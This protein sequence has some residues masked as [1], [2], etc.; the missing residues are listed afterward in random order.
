MRFEPGC[1]GF[2]VQYFLHF[3]SN[4]AFHAHFN[5]LATTCIKRKANKDWLQFCKRHW[6]RTLYSPVTFGYF[7]TR[8]SILLYNCKKMSDSFNKKMYE[9]VTVLVKCRKTRSK[10]CLFCFRLCLYKLMINMVE[11]MIKINYF[12]LSLK[13]TV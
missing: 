9:L 4:Y 6:D 13:K 2:L 1:P 7:S 12:D 5:V 8:L 3:N 10:H 11:M